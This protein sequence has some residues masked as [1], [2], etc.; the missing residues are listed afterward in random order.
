MYAKDIIHSIACLVLIMIPYIACGPLGK[1]WWTSSVSVIMFFTIIGW[2]FTGGHCLFPSADTGNKDIAAYGITAAFVS[3]ALFVDKWAGEQGKWWK[4]LISF[5]IDFL[6]IK[7]AGM[8][9]GNQWF[10]A[11]IWLFGTIHLVKKWYKKP[12]TVRL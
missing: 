12:V 11:F 8:L 2:V 10:C 9:T 5:I 3:N 1:K 6:F 4:W 7:S